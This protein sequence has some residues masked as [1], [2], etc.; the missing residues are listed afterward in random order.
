METSPNDLIFPMV[1]QTNHLYSALLYI[2]T[3]TQL[4][5][6]IIQFHCDF[7]CSTSTYIHPV[8]GHNFS[9]SLALPKRKDDAVDFAVHHLG[10]CGGHQRWAGAGS[11][12]AW[13]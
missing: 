2:Y 10:R 9:R 8:S 11:L 4:Y 3:I 1:H 7:Y 6:I 13:A 12:R 5:T